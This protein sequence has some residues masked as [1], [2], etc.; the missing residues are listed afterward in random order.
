MLGDS[1]VTGVA[2]VFIGSFEQ[3]NNGGATGV[4][5]GPIHRYE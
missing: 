1:L 2:I 5:V 4:L 3:M